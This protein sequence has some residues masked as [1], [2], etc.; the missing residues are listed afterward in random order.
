MAW[1]R[2]VTRPLDPSCS[3]RC[4]APV[5]GPMQGQGLLLLLLLCYRRC[6][7]LFVHGC[8]RVQGLYTRMFDWLVACIN[9]STACDVDDDTAA[10]LSTIGVLD[11]FGFEVRALATVSRVGKQRRRCLHALC[12]VLLDPMPAL[13]AQLLRAAVHKLRQR[14]PAATVQQ[15]MYQFVCLIAIFDLDRVCH[16]VGLWH[17]A[18]LTRVR[19]RTY[20]TA[21]NGSTWQRVYRGR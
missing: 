20:L 19:C 18:A 15:R 10:S 1:P 13:R 5:L 4:H 3:W 8:C 21:P 9:N 16:R 17:L 7:G 2:C 12:C 14:A 11:I 6:R